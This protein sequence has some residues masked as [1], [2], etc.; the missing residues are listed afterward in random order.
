MQEFSRQLLKVGRHQFA[1]P[2]GQSPYLWAETLVL[3]LVASWA[4]FLIVFFGLHPNGVEIFIVSLPI[5]MLTTMWFGILRLHQAA[6]EVFKDGSGAEPRIDALL[7]RVA[8]LSYAGFNYA[9]TAVLGAYYCL[10]PAAI[11]AHH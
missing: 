7:D 10:I 8:F 1:R 3:L 11:R 6:H 2:A 4:I 5:V 9:A